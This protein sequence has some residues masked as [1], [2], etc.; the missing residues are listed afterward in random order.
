MAILTTD[1]LI[2]GSNTGAVAGNATANAGAGTNLGKFCTSGTITD[3]SLNNLF[4]DV[5]GAENAA[6]NV[7]YQCFFLLNN[8]ASQDGLNGVIYISSEVAGGVS[9]AVGVD[10]TASSALAAGAAQGVTIATKNTP[11]AGV[12]FSTATTYA[13][14]TS[15]GGLVHQYVKGFWIRRTAANNSSLNNDGTTLGIALDTPA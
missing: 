5:T 9:T 1:L 2:K 11:P 7:D 8:N 14:G 13:T 6:S 10:P 3:A 15:Y 12:A 4:P